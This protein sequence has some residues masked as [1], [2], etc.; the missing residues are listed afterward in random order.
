MHPV[1]GRREI[2]PLMRRT[3]CFRKLAQVI[4]ELRLIVSR[5]RAALALPLCLAVTRVFWRR[6]CVAPAHTGLGLATD[7]RG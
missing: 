7:G 3:R 4:A 5:N 6:C 2:C 1:N